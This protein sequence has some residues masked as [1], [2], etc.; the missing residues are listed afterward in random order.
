M[1][2]LTAK[3]K[4][5]LLAL[6]GAIFVLV[7]AVALQAFLNRR[8]ALQA[9]VSDL[10]SQLSAS[11]AVMA[12]KQEWSEREAWLDANQPTDDPSTTEDDAKFYEFVETSA[13]QSGLQYTRKNAGARASSGPYVEV[14]DTSQVKGRMEPLVKWM[15]GLQ[16]PTAFRAIKQMTIKSAEPPE[17]VCDIEVARWYRAPEGKKP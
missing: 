8:R 1:R 5:L 16:Q 9:S 7:N 15:S 6:V 11:K 10:E 12:Q 14:V 4:K 2:A 13:R 3:E 17:L